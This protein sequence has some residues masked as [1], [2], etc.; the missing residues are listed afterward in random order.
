M[1]NGVS[2]RMGASKMIFYND[3]DPNSA[4]WLRELSVRNLIAPGEVCSHSITDLDPYRLGAF[5]QCHFFAGIGGWSYALRLAGWNDGNS[6]WTGSCPCQPFTTAGKGRGTS[7][8]RDLW[9][10][11]FRLI[12]RV[13]PLTI[14]GEQVP[15]AI[16]HG[17]LDRT[18]DNLESIGYTT[19]AAI[20]G[21]DFVGAP[22]IR[23]RLWFGATLGYTDSKRRKIKPVS[24]EKWQNLL[25]VA[26]VGIGNP[27][28][29]FRTVECRDGKIRQI[30]TE[31]ELFPVV[32]GVPN[33]VAL[34]RG[35]G[36]AIVPQVAATFIKASRIAYGL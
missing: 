10:M 12:E 30:P 4:K 24:D 27:W 23:K 17:W 33:R 28:R 18:F 21:A 25:E 26:R 1:V 35:Y 9:P 11:W 13:R 2:D 19:W 32:D 8:E 15:N 16:N 7:D 31:P 5:T 20:L 34:L 29:N 36:N 3:N 14:F 22:H 6:V